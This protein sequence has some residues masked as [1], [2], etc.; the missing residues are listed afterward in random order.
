MVA[1]IN[2]NLSALIALRTLTAAADRG[3]V[4]VEAPVAKLRPPAE[5]DFPYASRK[6]RRSYKKRRKLLFRP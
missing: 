2:T 6:E 4:V 1:S 5:P 3:E